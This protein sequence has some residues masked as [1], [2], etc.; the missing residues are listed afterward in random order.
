ME[1][2][3]DNMFYVVFGAVVVYMAY[4]VLSKGGFRGAIFGSRVLRTVGEISVE[5]KGLISQV[6][7]VHVL[8]NG[9]AAMELTSKAPLSISMTGFTL[10]PVQTNQLASFLQ[11]AQ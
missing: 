6:V 4:Q 10:S 9:R 11:Q 5:R 1:H 2:V 7:R 8:E 3:M